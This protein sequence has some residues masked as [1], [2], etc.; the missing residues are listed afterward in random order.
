MP[1]ADA[2]NSDA[3]GGVGTLV[4]LSFDGDSWGGRQT[5]VQVVE[6]VFKVQG[7]NGA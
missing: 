6:V 3:S 4:L 1:I 2:V 7:H 5:P